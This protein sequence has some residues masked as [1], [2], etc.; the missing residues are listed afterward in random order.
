MD[1]VR[2]NERAKRDLEGE[3][4]REREKPSDEKS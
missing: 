4:R 3:R 1:R 2:E